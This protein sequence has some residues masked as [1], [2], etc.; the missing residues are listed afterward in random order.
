MLTFNDVGRLVEFTE[1]LGEHGRSALNSLRRG[2]LRLASISELTWDL[3]LACDAALGHIAMW[4]EDDRLDGQVLDPYELND[5][6][7]RLCGWGATPTME[8]AVKLLKEIRVVSLSSLRKGPGKWM[9]GGTERIWVKRWISG[10]RFEARMKEHAEMER[11]NAQ[12]TESLKAALDRLRGELD[13]PPA[14][15]ERG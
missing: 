2:F 8:S 10:V 1:G 14:Y 9:P 15:S 3:A 4:T 13:R 12:A 11:L 7:K 6:R 5:V